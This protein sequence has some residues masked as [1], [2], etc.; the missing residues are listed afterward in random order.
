M[1]LFNK[2]KKE[3]KVKENNGLINEDTAVLEKTVDSSEKI[4]LENKLNNLQEQIKEKNERLS[5]IIEKIG[6][7][8]KEYD[9]VI[10]KIIQSKKELRSQSNSDSNTYQKTVVNQDMDKI[11][12]E[13][14]KSKT[15]LKEIQDEIMKNSKMNEELEQRIRKNEPVFSDAETQKKKIDEELEQRKNEL[16]VL[17]KRLS[18]MKN[19]NIKNDAEG[20][21][22][23]VVEAASQIVAT[24][25]KRLQETTKELDVLRQLLDKERKAHNETKKKLQ[26]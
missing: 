24:T 10:G 4:E 8:K 1:G 16:E 2:F 5:T 18:G 15:K 22:K 9:E 13:I 23:S 7:S 25:N 6:L 3:N 11:S 26:N 19:S 12:K 14:C 21:S 20:D 17:K